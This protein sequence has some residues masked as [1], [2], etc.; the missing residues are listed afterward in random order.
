MCSPDQL[1][2]NID[3]RKF[4]KFMSKDYE[5]YIHNELLKEDFILFSIQGEGKFN[6]Q[7]KK[8]I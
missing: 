5:I 8:T 6:I 2:E 1:I 7:L 4:I 3:S